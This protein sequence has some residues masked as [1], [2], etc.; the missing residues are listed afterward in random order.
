[1]E[2]IDISNLQE[3][4]TSFDKKMLIIGQP[5]GVGLTTEMLKY[6]CKN[7]FF[8]EDFSVLILSDGHKSKAD[9]VD[10]AKDF[11]YSAYEYDTTF[12]FSTNTL[13][14]FNNVLSVINYK[15]NE[16][17]IV[18]NVKRN[19]KFK[20]AYID[21]DEDSEIL[22]YYLTDY[23]LLCSNQQIIATYDTE[24]SIFYIPENEDFIEKIIVSS[25]LSKKNRYELTKLD[26]YTYEY[27]KI[28]KG[29]FNGN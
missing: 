4:L 2:R 5:K 19:F 12:D 3:K 10:M 21:R 17:T 27:E 15:I 20:I 1:M 7:L 18:D 25:E 9:I 23:L 8:E 13:R 29:F 6:F 26:T 28:I 22:D 24:N 14:V 16:T 11:L